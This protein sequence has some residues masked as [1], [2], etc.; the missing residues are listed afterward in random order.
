MDIFKFELEEKLDQY[1][2]VKFDKE[3]KFKSLEVEKVSRE[4]L[5]KHKNENCLIIQTCFLLLH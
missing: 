5:I 2:A 4:P 3:S 1:F